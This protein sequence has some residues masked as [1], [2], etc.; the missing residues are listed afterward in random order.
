MQITL[1]EF[2]KNRE[3]GRRLIATYFFR[4]LLGT[5]NSGTISNRQDAQW[6]KHNFG[7]FLQDTWKVT[8]K[9]TL[10]YGV[11]WDYQRAFQELHD[12]NSAFAPSI[13]NP[14]AGGLLGATQYEGYGDK[15]CNCSFTDTY[16]YAIGPRLGIAYQFAPKTVLRVGWGL[17]YGTTPNVNYQLGGALGTGF[18][19][20][21]FTNP[22][23]GGAALAL[24][25]GLNYDPA[26]LYA[27]SLDPGIRPTPGQINAP[28]PYYD[29]SGARPGRIN[30]WNIAIQREF[31]RDLT[32]EAAYVGNRAVW[33]QADA[34]I[35]LNAMTEPRLSSFGFDIN[36]A[37][38]RA[39]V[40]HADE[41]GAGTSQRISRAI[42]RLSTRLDSRPG[43]PAISSVQLHRYALGSAGQHLV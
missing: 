29:R 30:Q 35:D 38:D 4:S 24:Q 7:M 27:A 1:S 5:V 28:P 14:A 26:N 41:F 25:N 32:V 6:R 36:N 3:R 11:R 13:P 34:L 31:L 42:C 22:S 9:L 37:A 18:N 40:D 8:R 33:L 10:D 16:P 15:R 43:A 21:T 39:L 19:T 20:L 12:R 23:F 17:V 2:R